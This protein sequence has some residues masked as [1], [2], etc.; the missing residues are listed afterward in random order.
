MVTFVNHNVSKVLTTKS[1]NEITGQQPLDCGENVV[2]PFRFFAVS[3]NLA[4][5]PV[6]ERVSKCITRL[7]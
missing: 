2:A 4:K 3:K 5:R 1:S 6:L 7:Q